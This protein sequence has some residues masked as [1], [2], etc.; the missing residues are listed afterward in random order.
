MHLDRLEN[1]VGIIGT[2]LDWFKPSE[3]FQLVSV[4]KRHIIY[5]VCTVY[6]V[7]QSSVLGLLLFTYVLGDFIKIVCF[8]YYA[9]DTQLSI[10]SQSNNNN[11]NNNCTNSQK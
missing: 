10:S 3:H 7:P 9:D 1:D 6:I 4:K 11:N 2:A 5:Q 8:H